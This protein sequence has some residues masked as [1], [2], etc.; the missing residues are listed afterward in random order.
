MLQHIRRGLPS[1]RISLP[2][3]QP[4]AVIGREATERTLEGQDRGGR[5]MP[6][7]DGILPSRASK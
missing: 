2:L 3:S 1:P 5:K 7:G 4:G 6:R